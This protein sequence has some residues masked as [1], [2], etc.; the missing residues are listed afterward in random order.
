MTDAEKLQL[1][2]KFKALS[3]LDQRAIVA[4]RLGSPGGDRVPTMADRVNPTMR[5]TMDAPPQF[6]DDEIINR[7]R[8]QAQ[9]L[10][11]MML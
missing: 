9:Q 10:R 1:T 6:A 8:R 7:Q 4:M 11:R 2:A 5:H 3:P